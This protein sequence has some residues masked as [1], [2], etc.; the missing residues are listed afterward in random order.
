LLKRQLKLSL[1][2]LP[3]NNQTQWYPGHIA[4]LDRELDQYLKQLDLV[5]EVLDARIPISTWHQDLSERLRAKCPVLLVLNKSDLSDPNYTEPWLVQFRKTY[6]ATLAF[7]A[8]TGKGKNKMVEK[9]LALGEPKFKQLEAKGLKR[10]PLRVGVV[11]MPNVGK[12]SLI[13]ALVG[14]KKVKTGH[15]A[16]VTRQTQWVRIHPQ[17]ELLD[18]PGLIPP[19][20]ESE[21]IGIHLA[22]VYSIGD[23]AFE[24]EDVLPSFLTQVES[25]YPGMLQQVL[26]LPPISPLSIEA[27]ARRRGYLL[28]GDQEDL[29]R[30]AQAVLKDF[31]HG[32]LGR[33]TLER[34]V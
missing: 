18:T 9:L 4:K 21:E 32:R 26:D 10:R 25:L 20:L 5:V 2:R 33:L 12:S 14:K 28:P 30:T 34:P 3:L 31:R 11:G 17:V 1:N 15:R 19:R 27:I 23:R 13:N 7:E 22:W 16:G 6:P 29:R 24:E 8:T